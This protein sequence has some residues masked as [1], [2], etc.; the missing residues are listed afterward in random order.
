MAC[1]SGRRPRLATHCIRAAPRPAATCRSC[2]GRE[3][4]KRAVPHPPPGARRAGAAG[5][6]LSGCMRGLQTPRSTCLSRSASSLS[7]SAVSALVPSDLS[8]LLGRVL[9]DSND[10]P[11]TL[12][13]VT[14]GRGDDHQVRELYL[15]YLPVQN[16]NGPHKIVRNGRISKRGSLT[17]PAVLKICLALPQTVVE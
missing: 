14:L 15:W 8:R 5:G 3:G 4:G 16:H 10:R 17:L 12:V 9:S 1:S 7:L 6:G 11:R 2:R 13:T